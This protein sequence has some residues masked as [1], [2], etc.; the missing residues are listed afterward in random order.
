MT[1]GRE[2][3]SKAQI[4]SNFLSQRVYATAFLKARTEKLCGKFEI[5]SKADFLTF[6]SYEMEI[7]QPKK[8]ISK[9][10]FLRWQLL[11]V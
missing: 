4:A 9:H 6:K 11:I 8:R 7:F 10:Q 3:A 5:A 1:L 2:A